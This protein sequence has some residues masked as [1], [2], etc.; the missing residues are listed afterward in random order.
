[1]IDKQCDGY[2]L[3]RWSIIV[4]YYLADF[5]GVFW[6]VRDVQ[7]PWVRNQAEIMHGV[8]FRLLCLRSSVT[9]QRH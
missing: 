4:F 5:E 7:D 1:M 9:M 6:L 3:H 8:S 2:G